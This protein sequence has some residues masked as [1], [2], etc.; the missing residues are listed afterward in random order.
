M[1]Q[2]ST[3]E[4]GLPRMV[5]F[6]GG[7]SSK[8]GG[9]PR[10][11]VFQGG[12]SF[13]HWPPLQAMHLLCPMNLNPPQVS[14]P[15]YL[16]EGGVGSGHPPF[17]PDFTPRHAIGSLYQTAKYIKIKCLNLKQNVTGISAL[18]MMC[19]HIAEID[20]RQIC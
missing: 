19:I 2:I 14:S 4:G 18:A 8:E 10:R 12:W 13:P 15:A 20:M 7:W 9:L 16:P 11:V 6:Q 5:V 3:N 17:D 1:W